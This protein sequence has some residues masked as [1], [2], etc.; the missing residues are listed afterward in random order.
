MNL[1]VKVVD[2]GIAGV[3][4]SNKVDKVDAGSIAYMP[5]ECFGNVPVDTSHAIDVWAIGLIFYAML[6]GT[7]PFYNDDEKIM[8]NR[9]L[10]SPLK[11]PNDCPV[12]EQAKE[13]MTKMLE[14]DP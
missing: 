4:Q 1:D 3:C 11:F 5:P 6:Y 7:L 13:I 12:S 10:N 8:I 2:F 14:K 9:T